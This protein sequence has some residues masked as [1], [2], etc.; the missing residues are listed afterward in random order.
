MKKY[1]VYLEVGADSL[2]DYKKVISALFAKNIIL[3]MTD[4]IRSYSMGPYSSTKVLALGVCTEI[5]FEAIEWF[6]RSQGIRFENVLERYGEY[7]AKRELQ[8]VYR[9]DTGVSR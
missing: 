5:E 8:R 1:G 9:E 6:L 2:V 7:T 3:E 4:E